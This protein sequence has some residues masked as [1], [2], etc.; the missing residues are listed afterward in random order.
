MMMLMSAW[1]IKLG[2]KL[3][4]PNTYAA[5]I[6]MPITKVNAIPMMSKPVWLPAGDECS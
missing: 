2:I 5:A 4:L 6:A 1:L 3:C